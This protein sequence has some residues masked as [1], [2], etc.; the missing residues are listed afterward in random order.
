MGVVSRFASFQVDPRA[1]TL[2]KSSPYVGL[3]R[4]A[5]PSPVHSELAEKLQNITSKQ[6]KVVDAKTA[7]LL[8]PLPRDSPFIGTHRHA[9]P[10]PRSN[11]SPPSPLS[12]GPAALPLDAALPQND[13]ALGLFF[14]DESMLDTQDEEEVC[15]CLRPLCA[16]IDQEEQEYMPS[17]PFPS[18][19]LQSSPPRSKDI[20]CDDDASH[21]QANTSFLKAQQATVSIDKYLPHATL[22]HTLNNI[23]TT[24]N[25]G[26]ICLVSHSFAD[27]AKSVLTWHRLPVSLPPSADMYREDIA[28]QCSM[29]VQ[30]KKIEMPRCSDL[31]AE[32]L[33]VCPDVPLEI[34]WRFNRRLSGSGIAVKNHGQTVCKTGENKVVMLADAPVQKSYFEVILDEID[35]DVSWENPND[36]GLGVTS[37]LVTARKQMHCYDVADEVPNSWVVD[38]SRSSVFLVINN[39]QVAHYEFYGSV[40][41]VKGDRVGLML[42]PHA[43]SVYVNDI[44]EVC[45]KVPESAPVQGI[46]YPIFDLHG[47]T[48]QMTRSHVV[49]PLERK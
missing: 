10:S 21:L 22:C 9:P 25:F 27:V 5:P 18:L 6:N 23:M 28:K 33:D 32:L 4:H 30:A 20:C 2:P 47:R 3:Y 11:I 14:L 35:H 49:H 16:E 26:S 48:K 34:L 12:L 7:R 44:Q 24:S 39:E 45:L 38:F 19:F 8:S 40:N 46:L 1:C 13:A 36:F 17:K 37:S 41:L 29:W 42:E 43:I 15:F 31:Y